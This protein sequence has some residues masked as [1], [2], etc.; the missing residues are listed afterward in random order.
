MSENKPK[1]LFQA[2]TN[3]SQY[4]RR[5]MWTLLGLVASVAA[6]LALEF[7]L[8]EGE[9]VEEL[10]RIGSG[11][12]VIVAGAF[13]IRMGV[14]LYRALT[15]TTETIRVFSAGFTWERGGERYKY[16]WPQVRTFREGARPVKFLGR[17]LSTRGAQE[18][19]MR[20]GKTF[21]FTARHGDTDRFAKA[22]RRQIGEVTGTIMSRTLRNNKSVQIHPKLVIATGGLVADGDKIPWSRV[23]IKKQGNKLEILKLERDGQ[24]KSVRKYPIHQVDN[25]LGFLDLADSLVRNAQPQRF[26]I[27]VKG[28]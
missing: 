23:D 20:D 3:R 19:I 24:F 25:L 11:L 9:S 8:G 6:Y 21:A 26:N 14:Y 1:L 17:R 22:M 18:L 16:S 10:L 12:S 7:A 2:Q 4:V 28:V 5:F 15:T 13:F 27:P